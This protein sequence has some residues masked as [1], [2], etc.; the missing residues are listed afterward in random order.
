M[1]CPRRIV[2]LDPDE[3]V[4]VCSDSPR[5]CDEVELQPADIVIHEIDLRK[6]CGEIADSLGLERAF[7]SATPVVRQVWEL[8][9]LVHRPGD[10]LPAF[11]ALPVSD[12]DFNAAIH[13]LLDARRP[14]LLLLTATSR[15]SCA[16]MGRLIESGSKYFVL[17]HLLD[18]GEDGRFVLK[19]SRGSIF[20]GME[21]EPS[22]APSNVFRRRGDVWDVAYQGTQAAVR[23]NIGMIYLSY[24][25]V[26]PGRTVSLK[27]L[28]LV[29]HPEETIELGQGIKLAD[30]QAV[31]TYRERLND[32]DLELDEAEAHGDLSRG[33][34][35]REE[36]EMI[37]AELDRIIGLRGKL[38]RD[39]SSHDKISK[40]VRTAI[41]R[42]L[43]KLRERHEALARHIE[44]SLRTGPTRCYVPEIETVWQTR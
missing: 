8:G 1:D 27:D 31:D 11:L 22:Q 5:Y 33:E 42:A 25:L 35:L 16:A 4:A 26:H 17:D 20:G 28:Y 29:A 30:R 19:V 34:H 44:S 38:R 12:T 9:S 15:P 7:N 32:I 18:L 14:P 21:L 37:L 10:Y 24:L 13:R 2:E 23:H 43:K 39:S 6:L 41:S 40:S 36:K 3:I